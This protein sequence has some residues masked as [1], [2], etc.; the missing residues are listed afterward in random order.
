MLFFLFASC[1][2]NEKKRKM[3]GGLGGKIKLT[4]WIAFD[5]ENRKKNR[6]I[7]FLVSLMS[8]YVD[9]MFRDSPVFLSVIFLGGKESKYISY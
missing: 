3:L 2:A 7:F 9:R 1:I 4:N 6:K 8:D 5:I